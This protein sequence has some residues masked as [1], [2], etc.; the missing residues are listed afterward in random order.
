M[1]LDLLAS[2]VRVTETIDTFAGRF[3]SALEVLPLVP[4]VFMLRRGC[5]SLRLSVLV[6]YAAGLTMC[7]IAC[8]CC[9]SANIQYLSRSV[10]FQL[11]ELGG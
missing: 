10:C 6:A 9:G 1:S 2:E 7:L 4:R 8:G 5:L 3:S 11:L